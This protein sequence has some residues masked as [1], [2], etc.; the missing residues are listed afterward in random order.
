MV[1]R[2]IVNRKRSD[3]PPLKGT[4][5]LLGSV[6]L[7]CLESMILRLTLVFALLLSLTQ[8][9]DARADTRFNPYTGKW[10]LADPNDELQ[11]NPYE[12]KWELG[13]DRS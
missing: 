9:C 12:S 1:V 6:H 10:E 8:S 4:M 2:L 7:R 5:L 11:Y 13:T 3:P